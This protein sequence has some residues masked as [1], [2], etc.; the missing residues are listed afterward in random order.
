MEKIVIALLMSLGLFA[1]ITSL[2]KLDF[3]IAFETGLEDPTWQTV[4]F[5]I[6]AGV[7][8]WVALFAASVPPLKSLFHGLLEKMNLKSS[9][10]QSKGSSAGTLNT[11]RSHSQSTKVGEIDSSETGGPMGANVASMAEYKE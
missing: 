7:E 6:W 3:L 1:T 10:W 9:F 2:V 5:G 4:N 8:S 11:S